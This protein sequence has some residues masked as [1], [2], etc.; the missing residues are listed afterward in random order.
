MKL[1]QFT[2]GNLSQLRQ[3]LDQALRAVAEKNGIDLS[4]GAISF[5]SSNATVKL[6]MNTLNESGSIA[7]PKGAMY[8]SLYNLPENA[9]EREFTLQGQRFRLTELK[10][11]RPKN[12]CSI[13]RVSDKAQF[14]CTAE[15]VRRALMSA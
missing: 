8:L 1:T 14:K 6:T 11:N 3:D 4:L 7:V 10:S 12:P 5:S 15:A 13:E 2:K 9:F